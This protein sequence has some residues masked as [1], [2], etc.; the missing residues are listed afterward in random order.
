MKYIRHI[1]L[2]LMIS[3]CFSASL[4]ADD[5][6]WFEFS[7]DGRV[8]HI[9]N[10]HL[11]TPW[12]NRLTNGYL[13]AWVTEKGGIEVYMSDPAI[14]TLVNPQNV[15]G[16]FYITR[17]G[18]DGI[19]WINNPEGEESWECEVGMGYSR[20]IC[21][22]DGVN[23][24]VTYFI[25]SD[26]NVVLMLVHL[27]N[28][29]SS[30]V[31]LNIFS[32]V[33]WNLGD[34][35]KYILY[36]GDGRAGSQHNLYKKTTFSEN[37]I[38]ATQPNWLNTGDCRPWPYTGFFSAS[39]PVESF[40][41]IRRKF[42]GP[43]QN[44]AEPREV[45]EGR[46][47]NTEFWSEDDFPWGVLQNKR[48]LAPGGET[49]F[50]VILGMDRSRDAAAQI[51]DKYSD[52]STVKKEFSRL[53]SYY[54]DLI[55]DNINS[56]T[57]DSSNDMLNNIWTKYHWNQIMKKSQNDP[58]VVGT[59][60]WAYSLEGGDVS[61]MPEQVM[62]P[63]NKSFLEKEILYML[64]TQ[65]SDLSKTSLVVHLP[66]MKYEDL[67]ME[68]RP[69]FPAN[70]FNVPHHHSV[71][72]YMTSLLV[73]LKEYGDPA[74]LD[75]KV[76]YY[77]GTSGTIWDHID[78][79]FIISLSG[80]SVNGLPRIPENVGD[81]M[82]EFTK[83]S[84]YGEAESVMFGMELCYYLKE[85]ANIA[86][87]AGKNELQTKWEGEYEIMKNAI[88]KTSWNGNWYIRAFS[89]RDGKR[90]PVGTNEDEEGK[91]YLNAQSWSIIS[92]VATPERAEKA[93]NS[94]GS[95]MISDFGPMVFYP[96]YSEYK[97]YIG[98]QS[99]YAPGFRNGN[100]YMRPAGWAV[101]SACMAGKSKLAWEMYTKASLANQIRNI[102][103]YQCEPY[104]Y[105]ENYVGPEHRLAGKGEF[106]WCLGEATSWMWVA[107]NYYLLG[108]RP[109]FNG[110]VIDPRM[111]DN[112]DR[113]S[114]ERP[115]RG[116]HYTVIVTK[117][118]KLARGAVKI[119]LDGKAIEGN[120]IIPVM[121]GASHKVI[122][123]AGPAL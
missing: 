74:F 64:S 1:T 84:E 7:P 112:W 21:V 78:R 8:C 70:H 59:G 69:P 65:T 62:L 22:K 67:Q 115:F 51:V 71:W 122:V 34:R 33:E 32:Q 106:Q 49:E 53:T 81:W 86:R 76:D 24:E 25:P 114:V 15:S 47:S 117:N 77:E 89:D 123:E 100:I 90:I 12:F 63:F 66:A 37:T 75:R 60:T 102:E 73:Y 116:D 9:Y 20:L 17:D 105:P 88:N 44:F 42:L 57:P 55:N 11:P 43:M 4:R 31:N 113:Y 58:D 120:L 83:I 111:P 13:T 36:R 2:L 109:E 82:D 27:K 10:R 118:N 29:S 19:T 104:V 119:Q 79:A 99:I 52:L 68:S 45:L 110:L 50:A 107:Y 14:N 41:T 38:W 40:E 97:S 6:P 87:L 91:I 30:S 85:F 98:T 23:S 35:N 72:G 95:M 103:V 39:I 80:L 48:T 101:I 54:D 93:L 46:L 5:K 16:N 3:Y 56:F 26:D 92:G 121:D 108:I 96:S 28:L 61:T 94:V 18:S